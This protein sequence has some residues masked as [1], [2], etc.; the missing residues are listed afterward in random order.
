MSH[1]PNT[2]IK[3][4]VSGAS[5]SYY[6][7][8]EIRR[9]SVKQITNPEAYDILGNPVQGGLHDSC[10]GP[11][12]PPDRCLTCNLGYVECPGHYGH[13]ELCL[14]SYNP[15]LFKTLMGLMQATCLNCHH[16]KHGKGIIQYYIEELTLL[17]KGDVVAAK[18]LRELHD[19]QRF[20]RGSES[21][22][23]DRAEVMKMVEEFDVNMDDVE[24]EIDRM[25]AK[26]YGPAHKTTHFEDV[27]REILKDFMG[28]VNRS[29]P[30]GNC[31]A[32]SPAFRNGE[33]ARTKLFIMPLKP[34]HKKKNVSLNARLNFSSVEQE[35]EYGTWFSP[36]EMESHM[37]R[38]YQQERDIL[39]MLFGTLV[40]VQ[41]KS[42]KTAASSRKPVA[43]VRKFSLEMFF[44]RAIPVMPSKYRPPNFVNGRQSEHQFNSHYK[45]ALKANAALKRLMDNS[46]ADVAN[47]MVL[48]VCEV[49]FHINN[50]YDSSK[51]A[52]PNNKVAAGIK[53]VLERKEGLF[54]KH[55][56]GKRVNY[57]ARTVISPDISL[58]S[59]EMG[60][61]QYFAKTLTFPQPVTAVNYAQ[62][63]KAV[64]NGPD[65]YPGAN[66]IEDSMGHVI[67]LAR[68]TP[69]KREA[70]AKTLL[71]VPPQAPRG[72][73]I[74]VHRHLRDG[75]YVLANRQPTLHKPGISGHRV[76]VLGKM[77]KTLRMHYSN[78]STYNA[79]FDGDEMNIHFP[80]SMHA[81]TEI[82]EICANNLQYLGPRAGAPLRGLI[83][84][85]ISTGVLLTKRDTMFTRAEFQKVLYASL[86][87]INTSHPIVTPPPAIWRPVPLWTGK[88]LISA[89]LNHLT[90]GRVPLN[91][92]SASKI[93]SKMWGRSG[94]SDLMHDST[95]IIRGNEMLAGILDKGQFGAASNG[96][97]HTCYEL[98]DPNTAG[99]MLT[100]L[101]RMFTN[102]L[103]TRGFTCGVDDLLIS[104]KEE[105]FRVTEL[106]D[107]NAE[108]YQVAEKFAGSKNPSHSLMASLLKEE[109]EV[110]RLDG[111]LKKALN[112]HT[113]KIIDTLIPGGQRKAFP[114]NNFSLMTVSGAKG[115]VVNFSQVSC[116][117]GQQELEGKRVPR[118]VSGKTLPSYEP[119]DASARAGGFIMDRFLT[120]VRPQDYFF[121]CMA[122][123]EGLIDTAVKT[124]RSGYLQRCVIK[125]LEGLTVA[126]DGTV[127]DSDGSVIQF[128][129][130]EDALEITKLQYLHKFGMIAENFALFKSQFDY[131]ALVG[132]IDEKIVAENARLLALPV[133]ERDD[134]VMSRFN[135]ASQLGCVSEQFA[136]EL[137]K[138][139]DANPQQLLRTAKNKSGKVPEKE[140]RNLMYLYY[141]RSMVSPGEA[142]G[143]L[144]AQSIG[145]P[146]TQM[147]LNTFHLAG[148]GEA[149][150]TLG[151]P[152]LR[153]II[154][155]AS[156]QPST[157]LM[158]LTTKDPT[159]KEQVEKMAKAL[160][161]LK[162]SDIIADATV[163][164]SLTGE[165]RKYEVILKFIPGLKELFELK[166]I[167]DDDLPNIFLK[168]T[169]GVHRSVKQS[170]KKNLIDLAKGQAARSDTAE[171][172]DAGEGEEMDETTAPRPAASTKDNDSANA[173]SKS[174]KVQPVSY[175]DDEDSAK[176]KDSDDEDD[177]KDVDS[178]EGEA[179]EDNGDSE[180]DAHSGSSAKTQQSEFNFKTFSFA[181]TVPSNSIK[182]LMLNIVETHSF[183][184]IIK[185]CKGISRCFINE[186]QVGKTTEYSIQTEGVN[187]NELYNL[188]EDLQINRLYT[189][190]IAGVLRKYGVEACKNAI[191]NE[192]TSVFGAYGITVDKRH[193]T[194][195]ADYMTFEGGFRPLSRRGLENNPSPLQKMSF[196]TTCA[197]LQKSVLIN[198][199]D[200]CESPSARIVLGQVVRNGC[201]AFEIVTPIN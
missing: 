52:G 32:F 121:H 24:S 187:F 103:S 171:E 177:A 25:Q 69:E 168:F 139:I 42:P 162:M 155:T 96:L 160:E 84:D 153:E 88:Q 82:R 63:A 172:P 60:V 169:Q 109:R 70:L 4:E 157:P 131:D 36:M 117:L 17:G 73:C 10:L 29:T 195:L 67:N 15:V 58:E 164:E 174:N 101:G 189:N 85:H 152:R 140:F 181:I 196:E 3:N 64:M 51:A 180:D 184:F 159:N 77:E 186:K 41:D 97:V 130:G 191:V 125:H 37:K 92:S 100:L 22:K 188:Q 9:M 45:G 95:V 87:A 138:Y 112:S 193:L 62:M 115:S 40:R 120:G 175:E 198:D 102:Y 150:V 124:A 44:L 27:R 149:N 170:N 163:H 143:M 148:R 5:F 83:Q 122:G 76:K 31:Q 26:G 114:D 123:R 55:M 28:S 158:E 38:L 43:Y 128:L 98:Y 39:N 18:V 8:D 66:F 78:C 147:T 178:D 57:A 53:Q 173:K 89:A 179:S 106:A 133:A 2:A 165:G 108:G 119:Y 107:A 12:G 113:S 21:D 23:K 91:M 145:E 20:G 81:Q 199:T 79:D 144:C 16:F 86:W 185:S 201:G 34:A 99:S 176:A 132:D 94:I 200:S 141:H 167:D 90:I 48:N 136:S 68:E 30:C 7:P 118:M 50:I 75:D 93:P 110:A 182:V 46:D 59:N 13:I 166:K 146:S 1:N 71:T 190:D 56:M 49:Q 33:V 151:I 14:P 104:P 127:R 154:M 74:T 126:Y 80:Q 11:I 116:L 72:A 65:N 61:P 156:V 183:S 54:R 35:S 194:L 161:W 6:G 192:I 111:L 135:P 137:Q 19:L 142:V 47:K 129:Y 105:A 134:P 197:Y